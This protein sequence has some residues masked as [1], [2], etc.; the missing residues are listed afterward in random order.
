VGKVGARELLYARQDGLSTLAGMLGTGVGSS[1]RRVFGPIAT[2]EL[3]RT[4]R[5]GDGRSRRGIPVA[6]ALE[7]PEVQLVVPPRL[8]GLWLG[9]G[10]QPGTDSSSGS[11]LGVMHA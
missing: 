5:C 6:L 3:A 4:L 8:L 11:P 10:T 1:R 9:D 2:T 7:L